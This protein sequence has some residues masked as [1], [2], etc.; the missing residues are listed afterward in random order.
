[1]KKDIVIVSNNLLG[2]YL[3]YPQIPNQKTK[4]NSVIINKG[5]YIIPLDKI[6]IIDL[7][8]IAYISSS[9]KI[10]ENTLTGRISKRKFNKSYYPIFQKK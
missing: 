5:K 7:V 6:N 4:K 1:M 8:V 10:V 3:I 2:D 9:T